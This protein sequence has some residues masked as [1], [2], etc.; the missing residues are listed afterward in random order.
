MPIDLATGHV[1]VIWQGDAN[2][3]AL[4]AL[5]H[6]TTPTT[7]INVTGPETLSIRLLAAEFGRRFGRA[8]RLTGREAAVG[9]ISNARQMVD[10]FGPPRV[11]LERMI[12]WTADWLERGMASHGKPTHYEVRDGR[13]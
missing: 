1:N 12:D 2:G 3:V 13:F 4:R 8:P 11:P 7:P 6:T 5:A 10:E 9:W